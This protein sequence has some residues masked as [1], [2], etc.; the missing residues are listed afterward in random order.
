MQTAVSDKFADAEFYGKGPHESYWDRKESA[1][2]GVF[3]MPV[4]ELPYLYVRPQENG[5]R[6]DVRWLKLRGGK[7][8]ISVTGISAFDFSVW[9]WSPENLEAAT[10]I[11]KLE[12]R[13]MSH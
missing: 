9:P 5:N 1:R 7:E 13:D 11:N 2:L 6:S 8:Q 10:H 12:N 4:S 3:S